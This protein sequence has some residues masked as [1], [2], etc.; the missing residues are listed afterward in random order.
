MTRQKNKEGDSKVQ[1]NDSHE[2]LGRGET[3]DIPDLPMGVQ[4]WKKWN[5][6]ALLK[7]RVNVA[8]HGSNTCKDV[9]FMHC[10]IRNLF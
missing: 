2:I 6:C 9:F 3:S 5:E 7:N 8:V 1:S 4:V 10:K